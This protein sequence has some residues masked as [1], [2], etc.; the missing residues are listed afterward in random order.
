MP[1]ASTVQALKMNDGEKRATI[2]RYNERLDQYGH[3]SRTL[4]WTKRQHLLRYEVLLSYWNLS[5]ADLLDFGCGFGDMYA[6]CRESG[7]AD[8]RYHGVD[9]NARLIEAG[10]VR[11]PEADLRALDIAV[12]ELPQSY[13]VIVASGIYNYRM[14]DNW[15]F[16]RETFNLFRAK[17][18]RGFAANFITDRVDFRDDSL[19]NA[20]PCAV[21][22]LAYSYSKRV[23]LRQDYMPFEFTIFVDLQDDFDK[24]YTIFPE[25][26]GFIPA[27]EGDHE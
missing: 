22:D 23:V 7:R 13:D 6:Y 15:G 4:G 21:L 26:L 10:R 8:V 12:D 24:K 19:Y 3:S 9:L 11:Y 5:E 17:A 18:R 14:S 27:D 25:Y 2:A 1:N 16:I 20:D